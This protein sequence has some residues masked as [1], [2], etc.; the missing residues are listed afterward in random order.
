MIKHN[1]LEIDNAS[2]E[3]FLAVQT[4]D[5][6]RAILAIAAG[7]DINRKNKF[8][9]TPLHYARNSRIIKVLIEHKVNVN[10]RDNNGRPPMY[11]YAIERE[12]LGLA[13]AKSLIN[14][15]ADATIIDNF[16]ETAID[17]FC[18]EYG[19]TELHWWAGTGIVKQ[20]DKCLKSGMN[21]DARDYDGW[22]IL[23]YAAFFDNCDVIELLIGK[24]LFVDV[25]NL[26]GGTP[27]I[28]AVKNRATNAV[29]LLIK[30]KTTVNITIIGDY[31]PGFT[32]L[33][34]AAFS[35]NLKNTELLIQA[36]ANIDALDNAGKTALHHAIRMGSFDVAKILL[37]NDANPNA[38]DHDG[39][40]PLCY[41]IADKNE[42]IAGLL[43]DKGA[44]ITHGNFDYIALAKE[45]RM[46]VLVDRLEAIGRG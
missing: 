9:K 41:A 7:A 43:L 23:H 44:N 19:A 46:K 13:D 26:I 17:V 40:T 22:S 21:I 32:P 2:D 16:G 39:Y 42:K 4:G 37:D 10:I 18:N 25:I 20:V 6:Q 30:H 45:M 27:L 35:G 11:Y 5:L 31:N 29:R 12:R 8:G 15:G 33:H 14:N 34:F 38:I 36:D 3:L 28:Y 1:L 24:G